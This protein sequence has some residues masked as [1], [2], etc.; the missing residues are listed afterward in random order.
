MFRVFGAKFFTTRKEREKKMKNTLMVLSVVLFAI[1][2]DNTFLDISE[3]ECQSDADCD[4]GDDC[5]IGY[6]DISRVCLQV[7]SNV[8]GCFCIPTEEVCNGRDDDCDGETD[9][10]AID[11]FLIYFDRDGDGFGFDTPTAT[12][13]H[14]PTED[15]PPGYVTNADDCNDSDAAVN[16][17]AQELCDELD[18]DCDGETDEGCGECETSTDCDDGDNCTV[19][20]CEVG[21]VCRHTPSDDPA[22][23]PACATETRYRD[24]DGDG[25]GDPEFSAIV[26]V[27]A[28]PVEGARV[29]GDC[30]DHD[31]TIHPSATELCDEVDNDCDGETDEGVTETRYRDYDNDGY[32]DPELPRIVCVGDPIR[33]LLTGVRNADDCNDWSA[34]I[35]PGVAYDYCDGLDNDCDD[36]T[37]EAGGIHV[38][39]LEDL[40]VYDTGIPILGFR[41]VNDTCDNVVQLRYTIEELHRV[42]DGST[43]LDPCEVFDCSAYMYGRPYIRGYQSGWEFYLTTG[44]FDVEDGCLTGRNGGW[45]DSARY[46]ERDP[47]G[48]FVGSPPAGGYIDIVVTA[49]IRPD[50]PSGQYQF[51]LKDYWMSGALFD[52]IRTFTCDGAARGDGTPVPSEVGVPIL[53]P[54]FTV[55]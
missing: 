48:N 41:I 38:E 30:N 29:A 39:A 28:P 50:A 18:D 23:E 52:S 31:A 40:P 6:C 49:T 35:H 17:D 8:L 51:T 1:G 14:C 46:G 54:V 5:T 21:G 13:S 2:C 43:V 34:A 3:G 12:S 24:E 7:P 53:G 33:P 11:R 26:C 47:L 9:A 22:C 32:G 44:G 55:E 15:M 16:P 37:D 36:D 4:D 19:D 25:Y 42:D 45:V 10:D 20:L 27:D